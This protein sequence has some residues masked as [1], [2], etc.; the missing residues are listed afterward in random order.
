MARVV[1]LDKNISDHIPLLIDSGENCERAKN[2]RFEKWW[3]E[4]EDFK[5]VVKKAWAE[6]SNNVDPI[7]IWQFRVRTSRRMVR[8]WETNVVAELNRETSYL[9]NSIG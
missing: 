5:E 7:E 9:P 1:G 3:L 6:R 8:G 4:R 2:I